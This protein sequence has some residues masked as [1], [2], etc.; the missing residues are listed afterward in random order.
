VSPIGDPCRKVQTLVS[1]TE[2]SL[3]DRNKCRGGA[4]NGA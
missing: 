1:A 4:Y 2:G 3:A